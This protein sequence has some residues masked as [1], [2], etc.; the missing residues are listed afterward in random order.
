MYKADALLNH[1]KP[2]EALQCLDSVLDV[3]N[4]IAARH[5]HGV[6]ADVDAEIEE[7]ATKRQRVNNWFE[8]GEHRIEQNSAN[9]AL[10]DADKRRSL[11][12]QNI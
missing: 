6:M 9:A 11:K 10:F 7:R 5:E 8:V 12:V 4:A 2:E 1:E 3:L